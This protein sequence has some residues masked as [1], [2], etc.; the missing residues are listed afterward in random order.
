MTYA[1]QSDVTDVFGV[2]NIARWSNLDN[3]V[4]DT[5][6][7][8]RVDRA[9][10]WATNIVNDRLRDTQYALPLTDPTTGSTP[11]VVVDWTAKL[12]GIWLY[13][14][15]GFDDAGN[16]TGEAARLTNMK[17]AVHSE[18]NAYVSGQWRM[19]ATKAT[20]YR[21]NAPRVV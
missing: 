2:T 21:G 14:E 11:P 16:M 8:T 18:I 15:R 5:I 20:Q 1:T 17:M 6:V 13:Q 9:L 12:A 19:N 7:T 3:D 10:A 4:A